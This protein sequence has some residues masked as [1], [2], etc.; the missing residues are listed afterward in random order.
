MPVLD[1]RGLSKDYELH[2]VATLS[3]DIDEMDALSLDYWLSKFVMEVAKKTGERY[4]AKRIVN[5]W[6]VVVNKTFY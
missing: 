2:K 1:P 6:Y 4:R 5:E 3:S